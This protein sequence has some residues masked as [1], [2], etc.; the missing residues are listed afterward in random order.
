M[1]SVGYQWGT[2]ATT[3][4]TH[5]GVAVPACTWAE[6]TFPDPLFVSQTK[7][8][9]KGSG[10]ATHKHNVNCNKR[11]QPERHGTKD[12]QCSTRV[13]NGTHRRLAL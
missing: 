12:A 2:A 6:V 4:H 5:E 1:V 7:C 8:A 3:C 9:N 10:A 11:S 13:E